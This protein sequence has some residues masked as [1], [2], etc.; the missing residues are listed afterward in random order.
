MANGKILAFIYLKIIY[1]KIRKKSLHRNANPRKARLIARECDKIS[2]FVAL[3]KKNRD[4][5]TY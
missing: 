1:P 4:T 2:K 3:W 5:Y